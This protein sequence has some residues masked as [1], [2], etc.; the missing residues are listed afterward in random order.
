MGWEPEVPACPSVMWWPSWFGTKVLQVQVQENLHLI[1]ASLSGWKTGHDGLLHIPASLGRP[2]FCFLSQR[3]DLF[4]SQKCPG[5]HGD[6]CGHCRWRLHD[7]VPTLRLLFPHLPVRCS[8]CGMKPSRS[9]SQSSVRRITVRGSICRPAKERRKRNKE[10]KKQMWYLFPPR[11]EHHVRG[12]AKKS[13]F[14]SQNP[15]KRS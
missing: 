9:I 12:F 5:L 13:C 11:A 8:F 4:Y 6:L 14:P 3:C 2:T 7:T 10:T 1:S 15:T